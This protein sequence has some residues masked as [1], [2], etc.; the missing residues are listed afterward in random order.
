[1]GDNRTIKLRVD[2][3]FN[4]VNLN[5]EQ[6]FDF[7]EMLSLRIT[8]QQAYKI[9]C[10]NYGVLVGK[11]KAN[12]GYPIKNAK[13]S[14]FIP[15]DVKDAQNDVIREVYPFTTPTQTYPS[16]I[17]YNLLPRD[18][19]LGTPADHTPVGTFP[20]KYDIMT[21]ETLLYVHEKYYKYTTT[22]NANG[23]YMFFGIPTGTQIIH[24]DVDLS[25][26]GNNSVT[27]SDL[28]NLGYSESLF[29]SVSKFK[30]SNDLDQLAQ[31]VGQ[32]KTVFIRPFWGD[33]DECEYGVTRQDFD[34]MRFVFPKAYLIG[35]IYTD[36]S[37][38]DANGFIPKSCWQR[39]SSNAVSA[40]GTKAGVSRVV[41]LNSLRTPQEVASEPGAGKYGR[42]GVI[43]ACR[44]TVD[45]KTEYAGKW[46]TKGDGSFMIP[47]PLNLGKKTWDEDSQSWVDDEEEGFATYAD[48]R[49]KFYWEKQGDGVREGGIN[50]NFYDQP[51]ISNYY[52]PSQTYM[53]ASGG[54]NAGW[55]L[56]ADWS[57]GW[58]FLIQDDVGAT[59]ATLGV[60]QWIGTWY[61]NMG[62]DKSKSN[63]GVLFLP[64]PWKDTT[65]PSNSE[66]NSYTFF[67]EPELIDIDSATFNMKDQF[68]N[69]LGK[70]G[71][72]TRL[73]LS[74][75]YTVAQYFNYISDYDVA[76]VGR[77]PGGFNEDD[78]CYSQGLT[79]QWY[80]GPSDPVYSNPS[81]PDFYGEN[82]PD[83]NFDSIGTNPWII[84]RGWVPETDE[85]KI[86]LPINY[87]F[88]Q[89]KR[90]DP[91]W[92]PIHTPDNPISMKDKGGFIS[93]YH[94]VGL[95]VLA[96]YNLAGN[97]NSTYMKDQCFSGDDF[98]GMRGN[99]SSVNFSYKYCVGSGINAADGVNYRVTTTGEGFGTSPDYIANN[100]YNCCQ[101]RT[102]TDLVAIPQ[103]N[104]GYYNSCQLCDWHQEYSGCHACEDGCYK[105]VGAQFHGEAM[106]WNLQGWYYCG[107]SI[108]F[109]EIDTCSASYCAN[110]LNNDNGEWTSTSLKMDGCNGCLQ[111]DSVWSDG[112]QFGMKGRGTSIFN[113]DAVPYSF[114]TYP[115]VSPDYATNVGISINGTQT[116]G[117][118]RDVPPSGTA[119]DN[120]VS[121][122]EGNRQIQ[123]NMMCG[124]FL[125]PAWGEYTVQI[126]LPYTAS[127]RTNGGIA[128]IHYCDTTK[129]DC[130]ADQN[131]RYSAATTQWWSARFT[132]S[133]LSWAGFAGDYGDRT[134]N[135]SS[136]YCPSFITAAQVP[137]HCT[138]LQKNIDVCGDSEV[139][140][141]LGSYNQEY[142]S[143]TEGLGGQASWRLRLKEGMAIRLG[144]RNANVCTTF[145][146][147]MDWEQ[148][149]GCGENCV[150]TCTGNESE[151]EGTS[152]TTPVIT[153]LAIPTFGLDEYICSPDGALYGCSLKRLEMSITNF[154]PLGNVDN[155]NPT[156]MESYSRK[157]SEPIHG[158]LYF[159]QYYVGTSDD[160]CCSRSNGDYED[161]SIYSPGDIHKKD[162]WEGYSLLYAGTF[163]EVDGTLYTRTYISTQND[164]AGGVPI[165]NGKYYNVRTIG[166]TDIVDITKTYPNF[167]LGPNQWADLDMNLPNSSANITGNFNYD[168]VL[169]KDDYSP[170]HTDAV[171]AGDGGMEFLQKKNFA[172]YDWLD[173]R[174]AQ[175]YPPEFNVNE[176]IYNTIPPQGEIPASW[177]WTTS[178]GWGN[179]NPFVITFPPMTTYLWFPESVSAHYH[180]YEQNVVGMEGGDGWVGRYPEWRAWLKPM[181]QSWYDN[182]SFWWKEIWPSSTVWTNSD[183]DVQSNPT[184]PY[185]LNQTF[186]N[187]Y[188]IQTTQNIGKEPWD[189]T[190]FNAYPLRKYYYFGINKNVSS[191][192]DQLKD[193][194]EN[195]QS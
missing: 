187:N 119:G 133:H 103:G 176:I 54:L 8:Q 158:S 42:Y 155:F 112:A 45:G 24:M 161:Y 72:Y 87:L 98:G 92:Q 145:S 30:K 21:N 46:R 79:G 55:Y 108:K 136:K 16:G 38:G 31:I 2:S 166:Q 51:N 143:E 150:G 39:Q 22:T 186:N 76:A 6:D 184:A 144:A 19:Q 117:N 49:F 37:A 83:W 10:S 41:T 5:L 100:S 32:N 102:S 29:E 66:A 126:K 194:L 18:K 192:L 63:R 188:G 154:T 89:Y 137:S 177:E 146:A 67:A 173:F 114:E 28:M 74:G 85:N 170:F 17:R 147:N 167:R 195:V 120:R 116:Y 183:G 48:Y 3:E 71:N 91:R 151:C 4:G 77:M 61:N 43:E 69:Q 75:Y 78:D 12:G 84:S 127:V 148:Y 26:I 162:I 142:P 118:V 34:T 90:K 14:V 94:T 138:A 168:L 115:D 52:G 64:N 82:G 171:A 47:V 152:D 130:D 101:K 60:N 169:N 141:E 27:P 9:F 113:E 178:A 193:T 81:N 107:G 23:D 70:W 156:G 97:T 111:T 128:G 33:I 159:P 73:R 180:I 25:D 7:L 191:A 35:S 122:A 68:G 164:P 175:Q 86:Q 160:Q 59:L 62:T 153:H 95:G 20:S 36:K 165:H 157:I 189:E 110:T 105:N 139:C 1:M 129:L 99:P 135:W 88:S 179:T 182:N 11:V 104:P 58:E 124:G 121:I 56:G 134:T 172:P 96:E 44:I 149:C 93:N 57:G 163:T 181:P 50:E 40:Q 185:S 53:F 140:D 132:R 123:G 65:E 190:I 106:R 174:L 13:L 131:W 109:K 80:N 125:A 15:I